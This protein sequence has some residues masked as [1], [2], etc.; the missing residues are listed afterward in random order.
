MKTYVRAVNFQMSES[1]LSH[2]ES[3]L[4]AALDRFGSRIAS[5]KLR[6]TDDHGP[7]HGTTIHCTLEAI[8]KNG[9]TVMVEQNAPDHFVAIDKA[10]GRM[11]R[12]VRRCINRKRDSRIREARPSLA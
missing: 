1:V 5:L 4:H 3:R 12:T 11:K 7:K 8:L 10:A 2:A 9:D 6:L